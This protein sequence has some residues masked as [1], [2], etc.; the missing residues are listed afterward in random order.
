MTETGW[1]SEYPG[2]TREPSWVWWDRDEHDDDLAG[3]HTRRD[4]ARY[5]RGAP[6]PFRRRFRDPANPLL[7]EERQP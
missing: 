1:R 2:Q 4:R 6:G 5:Q 3:F 7:P